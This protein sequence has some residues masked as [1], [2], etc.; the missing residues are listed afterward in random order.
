MSKRNLDR[1]NNGEI[2]PSFHKD[3]LRINPNLDLKERQRR[4]DQRTDMMATVLAAYPTTPTKKLA[5]EYNVTESYIMSL[6]SQYGITK[7]GR[8]KRE[9]KPVVKV[10]ASGKVV[11]SYAST[12]KAA[13]AE[14][15]NYHSLLRSIEAGKEINGFKFRFK[16]S[17]RPKRKFNIFDDDPFD[18]SGLS[19]E[20]LY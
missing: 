11:A 19:D 10:D 1:L 2:L 18:L 15:I 8:N 9:T 3:E 7:A 20:E 14:G 4:I 17:A 12:N 5:K 16:K 6:A 13:I